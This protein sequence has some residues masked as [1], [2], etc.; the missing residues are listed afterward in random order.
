[1][2]LLCPVTHEENI[3]SVKTN[4]K[5]ASWVLVRPAVLWIYLFILTSV[6]LEQRG[7]SWTMKCGYMLLLFLA[8]LQTR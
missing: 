3:H 1:M 4:K 2:L 7:L 8:I 5:P 6:G